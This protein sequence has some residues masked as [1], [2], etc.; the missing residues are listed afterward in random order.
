MR[1]LNNKGMTLT[2]LLLAM[3]ILAIVMAQVANI[4]YSTTRL[5]TRGNSEVTLQTEAQQVVSIV[6]ELLVDCDGSVSYGSNKITIDNKATYLSD[7]VI[8]L[9]GDK[10]YL[11]TTDSA[12]NT[13]KQLMT[14]DVKSLDLKLGNDF[15][16]G[17]K[18]LISV[19][20]DNGTYSYASNKDIYFRNHIGSKDN[21]VGTYSEPK[22]T[23]KNDPSVDGE[24][25]LDMEIL[26]Y[27][28]YDLTKEIPDSYKKDYNLKNCTFKPV[29]RSTDASGKVIYVDYVNNPYYEMDGTTKIKST[30]DYNKKNVGTGE[31]YVLF[32]ST[33]NKSFFLKCYSSDVVFG[34]VAY[35]SDDAGSLTLFTVD[36]DKP[37]YATIACDT[38]N[39]SSKSP[40]FIKAS[41]ISLEDCDTL[42]VTSMIRVNPNFNDSKKTD[43]DDKLGKDGLNY[44]RITYGGK[45]KSPTDSDIIELM[46]AGDVTDNIIKAVGTDYEGFTNDTVCVE[47]DSKS[48]SK[49]AGLCVSGFDSKEIHIDLAPGFPDGEDMSKTNMDF[50]YKNN[51]IE[52]AFNVEYTFGAT[53]YGEVKKSG[54]YVDKSNNSVAIA[55]GRYKVMNCQVSG[56]QM[57]KASKMYASGVEIYFD[58]QLTYNNGAVYG[59]QN[60]NCKAVLSPYCTNNDCDGAVLSSEALSTLKN[61]AYSGTAANVEKV[62]GKN[63]S[64]Q[65]IEY[66]QFKT[67][68]K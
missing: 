66:Y 67:S 4:I 53:Q 16:Y 2:E 39:N 3:G 21:G 6:E 59:N 31:D 41:G 42:T 5:Y 65:P 1:N 61:A 13:S 26:R 48:S 22:D 28:T 49:S 10:L 37:T 44:Y 33:E 52:K 35:K 47:L 62:E 19:T 38:C 51:G 24:N 11:T 50:D 23:K 40:M 58:I 30:A 12:G 18:A 63:A 7:Y 25:L 64:D 43:K 46:Y 55:T 34:S 45:I 56:S 60:Y 8:E 68:T 36:G 54:I 15:D 27:K 9:V 57:A 29:Q 14:S 32:Q 17:S 20:M